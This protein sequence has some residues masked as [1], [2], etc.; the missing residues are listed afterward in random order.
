[1]DRLFMLFCLCAALNINA[2]VLLPKTN[3]I[4]VQSG[5]YNVSIDS[6]GLIYYD[7]SKTLNYDQALKL[8]TDN[9][10]SELKGSVLPSKYTRGQFNNWIYFSLQNTDSLAVPIIIKA[11]LA[12]DSIF[13]FRDGT[14]IQSGLIDRLPVKD[15]FGILS[16]GFINSFYLSVH[17][18]TII[19]ILIKNY[20]YSYSTGSNIPKVSDLR[21][22]EARYLRENNS[23]ILFYSSGLFITITILFIFGFQW[24]F[25]KEKVYLWYSLYAL[26]SLFVIWRNL[27][28]LQ[29]HLYST[30]QLISWTDSKVFH[31]VAVF[32]SYIVFCI[33][34]LDY[35]LPI[36]KKV[37]KLLTWI[38]ILFL[39]TEVVFIL[40]DSDLYIRWLLY[41]AVRMIL[42]VFGII[43]I[44]ISA[45]SKHQLMKYIVAG[46][47]VMALAEIISMFFGGQWSS[48]ISLIGVYVDFILFSVALGIRAN[49]IYN[50][51]L[52]LKMENLRLANEKEFAATQLKI[53]IA[54]DIHDELGAGLTSANFVL[55]SMI[56]TNKD[57]SIDSDIKRLISFNNNMVIQMHDIVWSMDISKDSIDEFCSDLRGVVHNFLANNGLDGK[58]VCEHEHKEILINGFL[59]RNLLMCIKEI[60]NNAAKHSGASR[61][62]IKVSV[63]ESKLNFQICD[64]GKGFD[65]SISIKPMNGNGIKNIIKRVDECGGLVKFSVNGGAVIQIEVPLG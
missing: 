55:H 35:S 32:Y 39:M 65:K 14:L 53:R 16:I 2:N 25:S 18:N 41:K 13:V 30:Y 24:V 49:L 7:K 11:A 51:K 21:I 19:D 6:C 54:K 15:S 28:D 27:E 44:V 38:C 20:D 40:I 48:S 59:R 57:T 10:F 43:T 17:G 34:F 62:D 5:M 64:N 26:S 22:Y 23:L 12:L 46:G 52:Y 36:L 42:T 63:I 60:L 50:E 29:P 58:F 1:M 4:S 37:V 8:L 3:S 9:K 47:I 56:N 45:R 33:T 61:I 31:T